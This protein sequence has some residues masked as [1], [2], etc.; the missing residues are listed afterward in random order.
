MTVREMMELLRNMPSDAEVVCYD[1]NSADALGSVGEVELRDGHN[2]PA[3]YR[4][5]P[6]VW[7]GLAGQG[8]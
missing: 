3:A 6:Y 7:I 4:Q 5:Y 2:A 8:W 1:D